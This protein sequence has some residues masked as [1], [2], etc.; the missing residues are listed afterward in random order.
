MQQAQLVLNN[1]FSF[2]ILFWSGVYMGSALKHIFGSLTSQF[3]AGIILLNLC[4]HS[5]AETLLLPNVSCQ[6]LQFTFS[7]WQMQWFHIINLVLSTCSFRIFEP[8]LVYCIAT[9]KYDWCLEITSHETKTRVFSSKIKWEVCCVIYYLGIFGF[10]GHL[11]LND[12]FAIWVRIIPILLLWVQENLC[13]FL[14]YV[15]FWSI[16]LATVL[17]FREIETSCKNVSYSLVF[18]PAFTLGRL[19]EQQS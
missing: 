1:V 14:R 12:C 10:F 9:E 13:D 19:V 8:A 6:R 7:W 5:G 17:L 11:I 2:L 3:I 16:L 18:I 15:E 4:L